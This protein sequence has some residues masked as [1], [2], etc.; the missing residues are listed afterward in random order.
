MRGACGRDLR[1]AVLLGRA[2]ALLSRKRSGGTLF[3]LRASA[4]TSRQRPG[5]QPRRGVQHPDAMKLIMK[6]TWLA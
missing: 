2:N 6:R 4:Q 5:R 1:K 3:T